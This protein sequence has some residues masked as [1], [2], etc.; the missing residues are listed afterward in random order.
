MTHEEKIRKRSL[1][2]ASM[3]DL[4]LGTVIRDRRSLVIYVI[5]HWSEDVV[6]AVRTGHDQRED[7]F[8]FVGRKIKRLAICDWLIDPL[9]RYGE[10]QLRKAHKLIDNLHNLTLALTVEVQRAQEAIAP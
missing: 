7:E 5:V 6:C 2:P 4:H 10:D 1:T 3:H 9:Y 8:A